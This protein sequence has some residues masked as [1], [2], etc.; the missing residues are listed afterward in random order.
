MDPFFDGG[1]LVDQLLDKSLNLSRSNHRYFADS[2][3]HRQ[4]LRIVQALAMVFSLKRTWDDRILTFLFDENNQHNVTFIVECIIG[5]L[6][7]SKRI[8]DILKKVNY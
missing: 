3:H 5:A 6:L 7:D 8:E 4:K 1:H 2:M